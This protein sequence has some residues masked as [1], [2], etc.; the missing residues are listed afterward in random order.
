VSP[1]VSSFANNPAGAGASI[2]PLLD[3]ASGMVP[4]AEQAQA[5]VFLRATGGM[6]LVAEPQ[7]ALL[8]DS[9]YAAM[10]SH[11]CA[12]KA[13]REA[14]DTLSGQLEGVYGFLAV[15]HLLARVGQVR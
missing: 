10:R 8:Y 14:F 6:R 11:P 15:N 3:L 5:V 4:A 2:H 12:I 13:P 1:G 7:R 9:L